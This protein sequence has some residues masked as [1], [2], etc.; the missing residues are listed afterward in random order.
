MIIQER[1][2]HDSHRY[3]FELVVFSAGRVHQKLRMTAEE[4]AVLID[5]ALEAGGVSDTVRGQLPPAYKPPVY[6]GT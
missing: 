6:R 5:T 3:P 1:E 4:L 2:A